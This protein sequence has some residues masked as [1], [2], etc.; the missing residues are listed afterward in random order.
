LGFSPDSSL[1]RKV[2]KERR[3]LSADSM[4]DSWAMTAN[5]TW[6]GSWRLA[7]G[8]TKA[9]E[10]VKTYPDVLNTTSAVPLLSP[11]AFCTGVTERTGWFPSKLRCMSPNEVG[12]PLSRLHCTVTSVPLLNLSG[13]ESVNARENE[14][15][16]K[17][18]LECWYTVLSSCESRRIS[19]GNS[20]KNG[21]HVQ[22]AVRGLR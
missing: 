21:Q 7:I 3:H 9:A 10:V 13:N 14:N 22:P 15:T 18:R 2:T 12:S 6:L 16:R 4:Y 8:Y 11:A 20:R 5:R 17:K 1:G 19:V